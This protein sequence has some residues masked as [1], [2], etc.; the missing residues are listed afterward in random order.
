MTTPTY[1]E[2]FCC[3]NC[4]DAV[5]ITET[6]SGEL[7]YQCSNP[8]CQKAVSVDCPEALALIEDIVLKIPVRRKV[9]ATADLDF[10]QDEPTIRAQL[11]AEGLREA[12]E[13]ESGYYAIVMEW[14]K[15]RKV[16]AC[17]I[18]QP[19]PAPVRRFFSYREAKGR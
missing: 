6:P 4:H 5:M 15:P 18:G 12:A 1:S 17:P 3:G 8:G 16:W 13:H 11:A 2:I 9:E 14:G 10:S 7:V 19:K